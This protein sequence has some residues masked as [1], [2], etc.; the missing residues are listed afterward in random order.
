MEERILLPAARS[1]LGGKSLP[2]AE[3]LH[4]DHGALAA[5]LVP[6]PTKTIVDALRGILQRH[7]AIEEHPGGV[8]EQCEQLANLDSDAVFARLRATPEV[9]IAP[10]TDSAIAIES[11]RTALKRAGYSFEI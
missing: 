4:L 3:Q 2:Q 6:S 8:Y 5:L 7:N 10:Y 11:L 9:A 1:V